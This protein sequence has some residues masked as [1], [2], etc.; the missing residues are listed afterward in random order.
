[1][2]FL[3]KF[4]FLNHHSKTQLKLA[5]ASKSTYPTTEKVHFEQSNTLL[6]SSYLTAMM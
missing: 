5:L 2:N 4:K 1:M 6:P 3:M